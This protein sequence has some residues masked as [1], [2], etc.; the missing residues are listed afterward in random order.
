MRRF[1]YQVQRPAQSS[2]VKGMVWGYLSVTKLLLSSIAASCTASLNLERT[3]R[4]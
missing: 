1:K 2:S 3:Q 4:L